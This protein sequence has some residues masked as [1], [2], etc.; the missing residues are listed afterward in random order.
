MK[1][2]FTPEEIKDFYMSL[3]NQLQGEAIL[4]DTMLPKNINTLSTQDVYNVG[5]STGQIDG[6][7]S[8]MKE[9]A[10]FFELI[11]ESEIPK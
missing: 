5:H 10:L 4:Y 2:I 8:I 6:K 9:I 7:F 1:T 3:A 11:D